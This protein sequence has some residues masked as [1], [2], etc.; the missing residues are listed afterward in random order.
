MT[1]DEDEP[2]VDS[3]ATE[4]EVADR[5]AIDRELDDREAIDGEPIDA[6]AI[7]DSAIDVA[8]IEAADLDSV[9]VDPAV[10]DADDERPGA[11]VSVAV[12]GAG[13]IGT[14]CAY[15]L[16]RR[17]ADVTLYDRGSIASGASGRAAGLCYDAHASRPDAEIGRE[18]IE[19]FR[20]LSGDDTF[21]FTECPYVWLARDGD[22]ARAAAIREA[23]TRM[24]ERGIVAVTMDADA[25]GDRFPSL[26]TDDVAVAGVAGGAGYTDPARYTACLAA[27]ANGAGTTIELET[28]VHVTTDP[29]G[30]V[31]RASGTARE[32][33]AVVVAAGAHTAAILEDAG[34]SI[35]VKPYRVQALVA[36]A[37]YHE[38]M[39][40]DAS[41]ETY[42]RP[43]PDGILVGNGTERVES[44]PDDWDRSA[45]D[46]FVES[47]LERVED[48]IPGLEPSVTRRWAGLCTATPDGDPLVG[49]IEDGVY[50]ATG[51]QGHG[52]MRA[53]AIGDRLARA[54]LGGDGIS[55]FD[56][57]RFDGDESFEVTP[58][59]A[60][61]IDE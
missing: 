30:V 24:Q 53:P 60:I 18:S 52:F 37:D 39:C 56:P 57:T 51:F 46:G 36:D 27:A 35:P 47:A 6:A 11:G 15:D 22:D 1:T 5:E 3:T 2:A 14:T 12:V 40:F 33:D 32:Y 34:V 26:R 16:A 9:D 17:G 59:M 55:A 38:P 7:D 58:G 10:A 8:G 23:V 42:V 45:D 29:A 19:R 31:E 25:L 48:R 50:V 13:A 21:P 43:H 44:D 28:P 49:A 20:R 4:R 41:V 61:D 54:V